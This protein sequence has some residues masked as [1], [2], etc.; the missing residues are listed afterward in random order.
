MTKESDVW[1]RINGARNGLNFSQL[2]VDSPYLD[3]QPELSKKLEITKGS[4]FDTKKKT[5]VAARFTAANR[6]V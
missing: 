1:C 3:Q 2:F 4:L 6:L 5:P